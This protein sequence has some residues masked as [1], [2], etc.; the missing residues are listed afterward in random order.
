MNEKIKVLA[1]QASSRYDQA[2]G[3]KLILDPEKFAELIV[4]ECIATVQK[5]CVG[6]HNRE[7]AEVMRCVADLKEHWGVEE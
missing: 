5:R 3:I 1:E 2:P 4:K 6:D 7:D